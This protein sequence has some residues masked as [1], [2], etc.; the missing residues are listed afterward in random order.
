MIRYVYNKGV[1]TASFDKSDEI[2]LYN[3]KLIRLNAANVQCK[4]KTIQNVNCKSLV[5]SNLI[6]GF[7]A[8]ID[9]EIL[10]AM[11]KRFFFSF[12]RQYQEKTTL[13]YFGCMYLFLLAQE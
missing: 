13:F 7:K 12:C 6:L 10:S 4:T 11:N 5:L 1:K 9:T 8:K 2:N 3:C